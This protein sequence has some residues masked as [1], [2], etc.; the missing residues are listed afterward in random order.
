MKASVARFSGL[1][2][3]FVAGCFVFDGDGGGFDGVPGPSITPEAP[4][5]VSTGRSFTIQAVF[6]PGAEEREVSPDIRWSSQWLDRFFS[7]SSSGDELRGSDHDWD[8]FRT[9]LESWCLRVSHERLDHGLAIDEDIR[10]YLEYVQAGI[11]MGN[12]LSMMAESPSPTEVYA[13]VDKIDPYIDNPDRFQP[14]PT[15]GKGGEVFIPVFEDAP[16]DAPFYA[17]LFSV[18]PQGATGS[19]TLALL[20][21]QYFRLALFGGSLIIYHCNVD[22]VVCHLDATVPAGRRDGEEGLDEDEEV[23]LAFVLTTN[24]VEAWHGVRDAVETSQRLVLAAAQARHADGGDAERATVLSWRGIVDSRLEVANLLVGVSPRLFEPDPSILVDL[25]APDGEFLGRGP[26]PASGDY[27]V[28]T[29]PSLSEQDRR[30]EEYLRATRVDPRDA[31]VVETLYQAIQEDHPDAFDYDVSAEEFFEGAGISADT[32]RRAALRLEQEAAAYGRA[33]LSDEDISGDPSSGTVE[34]VSGLTPSPQ[35]PSPAFLYSLTAGGV[36]F[37]D[38]QPDGLFYARNQEYGL[39]NF[40]P[41]IGYALRSIYGTLDFAVVALQRLLD[42]GDWDND[43]DEAEVV[44]QSVLSLLGEAAGEVPRR[45][46]VGLVGSRFILNPIVDSIEIGVFGIDEAEA[47]EPGM[48]E[49]WAGEAGLECATTGRIGVVECDPGD[50][51]IEVSA[52]LTRNGRTSGHGDSVAYLSAADV[53][54]PPALRNRFLGDRLIARG[55]LYLTHRRAGGRE[56]VVGFDIGPDMLSAD[57]TWRRN[58]MLPAGPAIFD[59]LGRLLTPAADEPTEPETTCAGLPYDL[60]LPLEDELMEAASGSDVIESSFAHYLSLARSAADE[61]DRLGEEIVQQ[62]YE[63][64]LRAEAARDRL[65]EICGTV[66][67]VPPLE[68]ATVTRCDGTETCPAGTRCVEGSC[69]L[70]DIEDMIDS[71]DGI[72]EQ[73]EQCIGFPQDELLVTASLGAERLCYF[74]PAPSPT[75][76][77]GGFACQCLLDDQSQCPQCPVSYDSHDPQRQCQ[78]GPGGVFQYLGSDYIAEPT[79]PLHM[80]NSPTRGAGPAD[81]MSLARLRHRSPPPGIDLDAL[82]SSV[83]SQGWINGSIMTS[84]AQSLSLSLDPEWHTTIRRGGSDWITTGN[85][86]DGVTSDD[87][88]PVWPCASMINED[89]GLNCDDLAIRQL[90]R[91]LLCGLGA[92][93]CNGLCGLNEERTVTEDG[94]VTNFAVLGGLY[95]SGSDLCIGRQSVYSRLWLAV[96]AA[97]QLVQLP[98]VTNGFTATGFDSHDPG[99]IEYYSTQVSLGIDSLDDDTTIERSDFVGPEEVSCLEYFDTDDPRNGSTARAVD[100]VTSFSNPELAYGTVYFDRDW[101]CNP[102]A[103]GATS[104][105]LS[106]SITMPFSVC[107]NALVSGEMA[108]LGIGHHYVEDEDYRRIWTPTDELSIYTFL[109]RQDH[110]TYFG[111][112]DYRE[113]TS[114]YEA[115]IWD[116][117]ELLCMYV[118]ENGGGGCALDTSTLPTLQSNNDFVRLERAL[119]CAAEGI[120]QRAGRLMLADLPRSIAD[121]IRNASISPTYPANRGELGESVAELRGS[122][123][124][125]TASLSQLGTALREFSY[126]LRM[127]RS[128]LRIAELEGDINRYQRMS[129]IS[130]HIT[131][132]INACSPSVS[133]GMSASV[134]FNPGAAIATCADSAVQTYVTDMIADLRNQEL[135]EQQRQT[136]S[137][138]AN[139][140][141]SSMDGLAE[142]SRNL[143]TS[144][145]NVNRILAH[146]DGQRREAARELARM[147]FEGEDEAGREFAVNRVM[148]ARMSTLLTRYSNARTDAV[149]MAWIARRAVEQ[150]MGVDLNDLTA[151]MSLVPAPASWADRIC[152]MT[153]IDYGAIREGE[154]TNYADGYI[155]DYVTL[156]ENFVESYRIDY[157]FQDGADIAVLSLK[158]DLLGTRV[159][160]DVEGHNQLLWS[161]DLSRGETEAGERGRGWITECSDTGRCPLILD[162]SSGPFS[163]HTLDEILIGGDED[164]LGGRPLGHVGGFRMVLGCDRD[165]FGPSDIPGVTPCMTE[166]G[167]G[168]GLSQEITELGTGV[169]LISW[170]ERI[171]DGSCP[172]APSDE[173]PGAWPSLRV[174]VT[175]DSGETEVLEP[176]GFMFADEEYVDECQW[177]RAFVPVYN[178]NSGS[179]RVRFE[180]ASGGETPGT[181]AEVVWAGPQVEYRGDVSVGEITPLPFFPTDDDHAYPV[182]LCED[183]EGD[184]FRNRWTYSCEYVCPDGFGGTCGDS[185]PDRALQRCFYET[186]FDLSLLEIERGELAPTGSIALGNFNYRIDSFAINLVGQNVRNCDNSETPSSCYSSGYIPYSLRHSPP[187]RVR[188]YF[189][190]T[191]ESRLF[192][193]NVEQAKSL[194]AERYVTNPPSSTDTQ[195]LGEYMREEFR[196]RPLE[197]NYRIRVYD[198]DGLDWEQLEDVQILMNYR[199]WTRFE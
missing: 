199:Y 159:P 102:L 195:L 67:N 166:P 41:R 105:C 10:E 103:L 61:A 23:S 75:N 113:N 142:A 117:L 155:G 128:E 132:C 44:R 14:F 64:D 175:N 26:V 144:Y 47:E 6:G 133:I 169:Y 137:E 188:N 58:T 129:G 150:R 76:P 165:A 86:Y 78:V 163:A 30:A 174:A 4:L 50:F 122:L 54:A 80:V 42:R 183:I 131:S 109:S 71:T 73:L 72:A 39:T 5:P 62:G 107:P 104:T 194:T 172:G 106:N 92:D 93:Y 176:E 196:G 148:R 81:C 177:R 145:A 51:R 77:G 49:L 123:E 127:A 116:A 33:I 197:G 16:D 167:Y 181:D 190:D 112:E 32:I 110:D 19:A 36:R 90:D 160:C 13:I 66:V 38:Y 146:L 141:S 22:G 179:L 46:D 121:Q 192:V 130:S 193:G 74:K 168:A 171:E 53:V 161:V 1:V 79:E 164:A 153:G 173:T 45:V 17:L 189:G 158:N 99:S 11:C 34:R 7:P 8:V 138:V 149:R 9:V 56:A 91:S 187:Y 89:D 151:E 98:V 59:A 178:E 134:S 28:V 48:F 21:S 31:S 191:Y 143:S 139:A 120:E 85:V 154:V 119:L 135:D 29:I 152:T 55:R 114:I 186:A 118:A 37:E 57:G 126:A 180:V 60:R 3:F 18:P 96:N 100:I 198:I 68:V 52:V 25:V 125:I 15:P 140:F 157:P 83:L 65:E 87:S 69:V 111:L 182:G 35:G 20:A 84:F 63:M 43:P 185:P 88:G 170:Y 124:G 82:A 40:T 136:L 101:R 108:S 115:S 12:L 97:R 2:V 27:P 24:M 162:Y 156:L 70:G 184:L 95:G 94:L 147:S